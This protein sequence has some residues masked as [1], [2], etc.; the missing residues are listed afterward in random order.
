MTDIEKCTFEEFKGKCVF[1]GQKF[2]CW[3]VSRSG[4]N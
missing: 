1:L 3:I 4:P 2:F